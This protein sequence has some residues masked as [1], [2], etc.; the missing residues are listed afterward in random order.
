VVGVGESANVT[1]LGQDAPGDDGA[2]PE[3]LG[4]R[5]ARRLDQFGDL[6][7]A[8]LDLLVE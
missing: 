4:Q 3:H 8:H 6:G 2:H 7:G 1:G 5:G